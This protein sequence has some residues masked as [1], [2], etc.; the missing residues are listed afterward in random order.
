MQADLQMIFLGA[1]VVYIG[2][3]KGSA[4]YD[5]TKKADEHFVQQWETSKDRKHVWFLMISKREK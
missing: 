5:C 3:Q 1:Q 4:E 2:E